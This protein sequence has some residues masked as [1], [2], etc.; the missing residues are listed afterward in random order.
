[1]QIAF[2]APLKPPDHPVPSGDRAMARLLIAALEKAGHAV[3]LPSRLRTHARDP[4]PPPDARD[5]IARIAAQWR[6]TGNPDLWFCYHPYYKAPDVLG[7]ALTRQ[8]AL[9]Y[10]TIE[11]SYAAKRDAGPWKERQALLIDAVRHARLNICFTRRDREG[12]LKIAAPE[13]CVLLPPFI[14]TSEIE[15]RSETAG[16]ARLIAVAMMRA[17]DKFAS[18][19]F[20]AKALGLIRDV[21]WHLSIVGDGERR[22][23]VHALFADF[24]PGRVDFL[25]EKL[26]EEVPRLLASHDIYV[27]PGCGEAFGLTYLEA[28]AAGLPAVAQETA[29]VPAVVRHD[30][31]GLLTPQGDVNAYAEAIRTLIIDRDR[32]H[33]LSADATQIVREHHSLDAA[34]ARLSAILEQAAR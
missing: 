29:G 5:E 8:F 24:P 31:T 34:S 21:P 22:S 26:P 1:M 32:R 4:S 18:Y 14:D 13:R 25:G 17:G 10:V 23:A 30:E 6:K 16:P 20:L 27:W 15:P 19:A 9:P 11:A 3:D 2:H 28:Q 33:R 7:P 12:L